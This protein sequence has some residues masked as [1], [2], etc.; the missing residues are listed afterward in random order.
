MRRRS[1]PRL[2][3]LACLA[4]ACV[5][6]LA[7][8]AADG[9]GPRPDRPPEHAGNPDRPRPKKPKRVRTVT[10]PPA[11]APAPPP[12]APPPPAEVPPEPPPAAVAPDPPKIA[13]RAYRP[14]AITQPRRVPPTA[15]PRTWIAPNEAALERRRARQPAAFVFRLT[16]PVRVEVVVERAA[17]CAVVRKF[18]MRG[19]AGLNRVALR[20]L[21]PGIY[22]VTVRTRREIARRAQ[23]AVMA[24]GRVRLLRGRVWQPC[25]APS[26]DRPRAAIASS[27]IAAAAPPAP[28]QRPKSRVDRTTDVLGAT[29]T[30]AVELVES[31]PPFL[32]AILAVAIALLALAVLPTRAAPSLRVAALLAYHR[33]LFVLAGAI[34]LIGTV[35]TYAVW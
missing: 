26:T 33:A 20:R 18:R 21:Q 23:I 35:V 8:G 28:P 16:R 24:K 29:F 19:R 17:N 31:V 5:A 12:A 13:T 25:A 3:W 4:V 1:P 15:A 14:R 9:R 6:P 10:P 32:F 7:V 2:T 30:R 34:A 27:P 22:R 11:P